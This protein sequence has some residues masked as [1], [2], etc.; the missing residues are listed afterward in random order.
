MEIKTEGPV[1]TAPEKKNFQRPVHTESESKCF[2]F[3][4]RREKFDKAKDTGHFGVLFEEFKHSREGNRVIIAMSS[5]SKA[6]F[7]KV[8]FL[9]HT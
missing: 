4:L 9:V 1:N 7:S 3:T 8:V 5:F 2:P 6:P